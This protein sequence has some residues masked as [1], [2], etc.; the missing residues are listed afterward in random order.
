M[1]KRT[2]ITSHTSSRRDSWWFLIQDDDGAL[3]VE[4]END[5]APEQ[6][7]TRWTINEFMQRGDA[8]R[9]LQQLID[10]MFENRNA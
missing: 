5:D 2:V 4:H 1:S 3:Y 10:R 6:G 7:K 8:K 9:E